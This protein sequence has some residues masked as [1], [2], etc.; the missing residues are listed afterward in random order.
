SL[1]ADLSRVAP[2]HDTVPGRQMIDAAIQR[3]LLKAALP[4]RCIDHALWGDAYPLPTFADMGS[5][6]RAALDQRRAAAALDGAMRGETARA[7]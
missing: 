2:D 6:L 1:V 5:G 3:A 4:S 7:A